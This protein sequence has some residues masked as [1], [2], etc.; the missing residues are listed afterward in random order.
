M[1]KKQKL[2]FAMLLICKR[3]I[4]KVIKFTSSKDRQHVEHQAYDKKSKGDGN[5]TKAEKVMLSHRCLLQTITIYI[6]TKRLFSWNAG[7]FSQK[8]MI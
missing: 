4:K 3:F 5:S 7:C 2:I 1:R 8:K 6:E